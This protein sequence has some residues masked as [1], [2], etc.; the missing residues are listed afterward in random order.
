MYVSR[1]IAVVIVALVPFAS[2]SA[3]AQSLPVQPQPPMDQSVPPPA[4][5]KA[6]TGDGP[7][8]IRG[9]H[10]GDP[11][12]MGYHPSQRV[13]GDLVLGGAATLVWSYPGA[14]YVGAAT[15]EKAFFMPVVGPFIEIG[16]LGIPHG[17]NGSTLDAIGLA[18]Y[19]SFDVICA[20][21]GVVQAAG[22]VMLVLG[23][24]VPK[25]VLVRNDLGAI[26]SIRPVPM[27]A[28]NMGGLGIAAQF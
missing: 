19:A 3:I 24:T 28:S 1:T 11:I 6:V 26:K 20:L 5:P 21:D 8:A 22:V 2:A 10:N 27:A 18:V 15:G 14:L 13:R 9:W 25:T 12:P 17:Y 7:P 16:R 4:P 23:L